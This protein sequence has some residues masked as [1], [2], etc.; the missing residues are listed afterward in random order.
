MCVYQC[1]TTEFSY[2]ITIDKFMILSSQ[3]GAYPWKEPCPLHV[4]LLSLASSFLF[5]PSSRIT[6][7]SWS[8]LRALTVPVTTLLSWRQR[9]PYTQ[10]SGRGCNILGLG[11]KLA[12]AREERGAWE[13]GLRV[14]VGVAGGGVIR[15]GQDDTEVTLAVDGG[16]S[17]WLRG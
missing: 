5:V 4:P 2:S 16:G 14:M 3:R 17:R 11:L 10:G 12:A 9:W 6:L 1:N 13:R 15:E 7:L 8:P